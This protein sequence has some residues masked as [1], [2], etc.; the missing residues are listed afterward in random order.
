ML[1]KRGSMTPGARRAA[2]VAVT[3]SISVSG[4]THFG[5]SL[6]ALAMIGGNEAANAPVGN[7]SANSKTSRI[8]MNPTPNEAVHIARFGLI[9]GD[10]DGVSASP[11]SVKLR[12]ATFA[13]KAGL[14]TEAPRLVRLR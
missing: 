7:S 5:T 2:L 6:P 3:K 13:I 11:P 4:A 10:F 1:S 14:P 8:F 12:R 9:L